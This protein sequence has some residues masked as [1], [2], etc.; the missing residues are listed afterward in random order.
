MSH[1]GIHA[2][3]P[4]VEG[5]AILVAPG[6]GLRGGERGVGREA[7]V[8]SC[9]RQS[10]EVLRTRKKVRVATNTTEE[11]YRSGTATA[12]QCWARGKLRLGRETE[13]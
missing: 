8:G 13:P 10:R 5:R 11:R 7:A 9:P 6:E 4:R 2:V 12:Y 3:L 1:L